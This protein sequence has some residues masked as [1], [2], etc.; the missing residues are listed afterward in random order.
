H[1][2]LWNG[3]HP[4]MPYKTVITAHQAGS[5]KPAPRHFTMAR[6]LIGGVPWLHAAQS[7]FHDVIPARALGIPDGWINRKGD[8]AADGGKPDR[9]CRT[10]TELA[11][12][13][14][15]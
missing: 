12:W 2:L 5:Y 14:A 10:L 11:D 7:Y 3:A 1:L 8:T 13:L 15:P 6:E 4:A 9:E